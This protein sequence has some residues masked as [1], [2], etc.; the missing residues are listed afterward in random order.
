VLPGATARY[1]LARASVAA[2][3]GTSV[4]ASVG[5]SV[6]TR[7]R[8]LAPSVGT[9]I[10]ASVGTCVGPPSSPGHLAKPVIP[11]GR[12]ASGQIDQVK[13]D[14]CVIV[15]IIHEIVDWIQIG[16]LDT[17]T[18]ASQPLTKKIEKERIIIV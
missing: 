7:A 3:V 2:S 18:V 8:L 15:R 10:G 1:P 12:P 14:S 5:A 6:G 11:Y 16:N 9:F 17:T 13:I 4:G